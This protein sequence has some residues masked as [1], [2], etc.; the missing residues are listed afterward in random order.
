MINNAQSIKKKIYRYI[1]YNS[2]ASHDLFIK[3]NE[4]GEKCCNPP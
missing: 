3:G 2:L 1:F 4:W